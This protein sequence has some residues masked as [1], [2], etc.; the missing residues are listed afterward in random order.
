MPNYIQDPNDTKKTV[1]GLQPDNA[2]DR[3]TTNPTTASFFKSPN[4]VYINKTPA[5]EIAFF[6]GSS[7]SFSDLGAAG[8]LLLAN[9][10]H[11]G[12]PTVGT[13]LNIHPT[14]WSGSAADNDDAAGI[15]TLMY[16]GGLDGGGI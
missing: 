12:Q 1:P 4:Y 3:V 6:F 14:A 13:Q 9:Y 2:Y 10:T 8:K 16:K 7:A 15:I 11:F 5:N